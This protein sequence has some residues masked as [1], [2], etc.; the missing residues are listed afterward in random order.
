MIG[1]V[2]AFEMHGVV[3]PVRSTTVSG[4]KLAVAVAM[5][6]A[7]TYGSVAAHAQ[8]AAPASGTG[9]ASAQTGEVQAAPRTAAE[10]KKLEEA[11]QLA[12]ITVTGI[13]ASVEKA[14]DIKR[15]ADTFV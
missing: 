4:A 9:S 1:K 3:R 12:G 2:Q 13:R 7:F 5:G 15:D 11:K 14:Q 8:D 6:L 10:K